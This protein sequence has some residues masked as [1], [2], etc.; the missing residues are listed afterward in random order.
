MNF[1][2]W[3]REFLRS[4]RNCDHLNFRKRE[5]KI[6]NSV[7][8]C[9]KNRNLKIIRSSKNCRISLLLLSN[10]SEILIF[11]N[12]EKATIYRRYSH[13]MSDQLNELHNRICCTLNRNTIFCLTQMKSSTNWGM[14]I[15]HDN[16][17]FVI[18]M[19]FFSLSK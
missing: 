16:T 15:R 9:E 11:D 19:H 6:K 17:L 5:I 7:N 14:T 13:T 18:L 2:R 1:C 12:A 10:C 3:F 8:S 4:P